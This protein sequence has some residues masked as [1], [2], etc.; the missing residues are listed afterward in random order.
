MWNTI[1]CI[2]PSW[3]YKQPSVPGIDKS[4]NGLRCRKMARRSPTSHTSAAVASTNNFDEPSASSHRSSIYISFFV[5]HCCSYTIQTTAKIFVVTQNKLHLNR[6]AVHK[7][8]DKSWKLRDDWV[9]R[10]KCC[11][12]MCDF[13][14]K[15]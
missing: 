8:A 14:G 13:S 1:K 12:E 9:L 11:R 6:S 3:K 5:C 2:I 15:R 10:S 4:T 7:K